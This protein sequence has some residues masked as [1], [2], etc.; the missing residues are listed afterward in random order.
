MNGK[1]R[2]IWRKKNGHIQFK[3]NALEDK[4]ITRALYQAAQAGVRVDLIVRDSCRLRPGIKGLSENVTVISV[5]GRFLEH[6][7]VYYF[8]NNGKEEYYIGSADLMKRNLEERVEVVCPIEALEHQQIL[9]EMLD[10]QFL[11]RRSCWEMDTD[12]NYNHRHGDQTKEDMTV[13]QILIDMAEK[14]SKSMIK[15]QKKK[16]LKGKKMRKRN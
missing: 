12:G 14:R 11:N 4:D 13:H 8:Y 7:R 1:W 16:R 5:V 10:V 2:F 3:C 15:P 9:R 6:S